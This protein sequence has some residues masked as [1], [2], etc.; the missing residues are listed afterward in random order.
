MTWDRFTELLPDSIAIDIDGCVVYSPIDEDGV[1]NV[2]V[3]NEDFD[4]R[5][6]MF[7]KEDNEAIEVDRGHNTFWLISSSGETH[8]CQLLGVMNV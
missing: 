7:L 5:F 2:T 6:L 1:V 4:T 8:T 3:N